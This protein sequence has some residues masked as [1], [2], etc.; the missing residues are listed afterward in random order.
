M[1]SEGKAEW[2]KRQQ[3]GVDKWKKVI[4]RERVSNKS[5]IKRQRQEEEREKGLRR[6]C[7]IMLAIKR[8]K[9]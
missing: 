2:W 7:Q 4:N 6:K 8:D 9:I 5:G 1:E 3:E